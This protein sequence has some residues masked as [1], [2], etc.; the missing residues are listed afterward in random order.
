MNK[1]KFMKFEWTNWRKNKK[2]NKMCIDLKRNLL[3]LK[4]FYLICNILYYKIIT[5]KF[6]KYYINSPKF[7]TL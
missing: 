7:Q 1:G 6:K 5:T 3:L 2:G 4:L